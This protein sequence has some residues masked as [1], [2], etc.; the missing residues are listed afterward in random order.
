MCAGVFDFRAPAWVSVHVKNALTS[1]ERDS[2]VNSIM[3]SALIYTDLS[4]WWRAKK[5]P[6]GRHLKGPSGPKDT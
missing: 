5:L 1:D 6:M 2:E 3:F 4:T